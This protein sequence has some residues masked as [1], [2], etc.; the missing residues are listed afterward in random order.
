MHK[1][2]A[3]WPHLC[4]WRFTDYHYSG[5]QIRKVKRKYYAPLSQS[6]IGH[7][8]IH[9]SSGEEIITIPTPLNSLDLP[10]V[11]YFSPRGGEAAVEIRWDVRCRGAWS[12]PLQRLQHPVPVVEGPGTQKREGEAGVQEALLRGGLARYW[13]R[14]RS[15]RGHVYFQ[16]L[17]T[18]P[19]HSAESKLQPQRTQQWGET[20]FMGN[21]IIWWNCINDSSRLRYYFFYYLLSNSEQWN[22]I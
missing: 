22:V 17:Q 15:C 10:L 13:E 3:L 5:L 2:T 18:G 20:R 11:I 12:G 1:S 19:T 9:F 8:T 7:R 16:P 6:H 4:F 14:P 21:E